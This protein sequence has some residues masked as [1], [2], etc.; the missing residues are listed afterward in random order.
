MA[1]FG[2]LPVQLPQGVTASIADG[3][4]SVAGPKGTLSKSFPRQVVVELKDNTLSV[5]QKG[6]SNFSRALQGTFRSHLVNMVK[7]V[8]EGWSRA[9]EISG[10]GYRT[11]VRGNTLVLNVGFSHPVNVDAP[12]G[13]AFKV[14]KQT[15]TV[16]G[17]DKEKVGHIASVVRAVRPPEPY[18]GAGIKY[19]EETIRRKAGKQAAKGA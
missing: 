12:E 15:I 3:T 11:E 18:K 10:A 14:E 16:F 6:S 9:L 4:V 17:I 5:A 13:I 2:K 8:T 7:G 19:Q 1:R